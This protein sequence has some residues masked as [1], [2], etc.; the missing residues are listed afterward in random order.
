MPRFGVAIANAVE[1]WRI[2]PASVAAA[3]PAPFLA[4]SKLAQRELKSVLTA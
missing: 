3:R 2:D 4:K 1:L